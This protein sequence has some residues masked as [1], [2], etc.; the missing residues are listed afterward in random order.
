LLHKCTLLFSSALATATPTNLAMPHS[1]PIYCGTKATPIFLA[2]PPSILVFFVTKTKPFLQS[3]CY[4]THPLSLPCS[5][6][7]LSTVGLRPRPFSTNTCVFATPHTTYVR[8]FEVGWSAND[9][10]FEKILRHSFLVQDPAMW[11][12]VRN[13]KLRKYFKTAKKLCLFI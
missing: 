11:I 10:Q 7:L 4:L 6:S 1:T 8:T 13:S 5:T 12:F 2:P 9:D 3:H